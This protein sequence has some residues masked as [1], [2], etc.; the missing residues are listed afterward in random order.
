MCDNGT[1]GIARLMPTTGATIWQRGL[2]GRPL[3]LTQAA[4]SVAVIDYNGDVQAVARVFDVATGQPRLNTV[5]FQTQEYAGMLAVDRTGNVYVL[6]SVGQSPSEMLVCM[7][8]AD[9]RVRWST[10]LGEEYLALSVGVV[11]GQVVLGGVDRSTFQQTPELR[12]LSAATGTLLAQQRTPQVTV[13]V[14]EDRVR[15]DW[16]SVLTLEPGLAVLSASRHH[17]VLGALSLPQLTGTS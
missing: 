2:P 13:P 9:G 4:G 6:T 11:G 8:G 10:P 16:D 3:A 5:L 17:D 15:S 7:D 12:L 1:G 14:G